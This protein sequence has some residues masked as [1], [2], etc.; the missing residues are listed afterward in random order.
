[1]PALGRDR[2]HARQ[3]LVELRGEEA[4]ATHLAVA[5]DV[6]ARRLLVAQ[7]HVDRVVEHLVEVDWTEL[8]AFGRGQ[9]RDE[10]GRPRM[11]SDDARQQTAA[12]PAFPSTAAKA[13]TRAGAA[14]NSCR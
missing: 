1:Q 6:D 14:T 10:P 8:P 11:R 7:R 13:K 4:R 3:V 2:H 5:D 9:P 12:H